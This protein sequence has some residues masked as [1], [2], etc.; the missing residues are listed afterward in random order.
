MTIF[1]AQYLQSSKNPHEY[2]SNVPLCDPQIT[3]RPFWQ[4]QGI[5]GHSKDKKEKLGNE[6]IF[7][8]SLFIKIWVMQWLHLFCFLT[9]NIKKHTADELKEIIYLRKGKS[10][11]LTSKE[12]ELNHQNNPEM[13]SSQLKSTFCFV[14]QPY[15]PPNWIVILSK[16]EGKKISISL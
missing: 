6:T 2:K 1:N 10:S 11:L 8:V 14:I 3:F 12:E 7:Q 16:K 15:Y 4:M 5:T 13:D 9:A